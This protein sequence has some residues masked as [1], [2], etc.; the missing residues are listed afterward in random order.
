MKNR[1]GNEPR[2]RNGVKP[3]GSEEQPKW[4]GTE[5]GGGE[6]GIQEGLENQVG[7]KKKKQGSGAGRL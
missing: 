5:D 6:W 7:E 1:T 2:K 4:E 3:Q